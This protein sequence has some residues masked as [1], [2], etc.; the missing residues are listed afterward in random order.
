[1]LRYIK[2]FFKTLFMEF[3]GIRTHSVSFHTSAVVKGFFVGKKS[4][5]VHS[6]KV[7]VRVNQ[8]FMSPNAVLHDLGN[9]TKVRVR[10]G[11]LIRNTCSCRD[12]TLYDLRDSVRA[13]N[14]YFQTVVISRNPT[15][16]SKVNEG[17]SYKTRVYPGNDMYHIRLM[18]IKRE[19]KIDKNKVLEALAEFLSDYKENL[20]HFEFVGYYKGV[21]IGHVERISIS[22]KDLMILLK[23]RGR[24]LK[25]DILLVKLKGMYKMIPVRD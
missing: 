2:E 9:K 23:K 24:N 17:I 16:R 20:K 5:G 10:E 25:V 21:P 4:I 19:K 18:R 3:K 14:T 6:E 13:F 1:M 8:V 12:V 11:D 15:F 7:F 22:K